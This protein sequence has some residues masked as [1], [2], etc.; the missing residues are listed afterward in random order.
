MW[1]MCL[2]RCAVN[3]SKAVQQMWY[4]YIT[5]P[6]MNELWS[7]HHDIGL[8]KTSLMLGSTTYLLAVNVI[9][10][11]DTNL[12]LWEESYS[13][14]TTLGVGRW[15][16]THSN[17]IGDQFSVIHNRLLLGNLNQTI[18]DEWRCEFAPIGSVLSININV[19]RK[20]LTIW[21][22]TSAWITCK[23]TRKSTSH[24]F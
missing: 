1:W 21:N 2:W 10:R 15:W 12:I 17:T 13:E 5:G 24:T 7:K 19:L 6:I 11:V 18:D 20:F 22:I 8:V 14:F 16:M 23:I 9:E 3:G 4:D